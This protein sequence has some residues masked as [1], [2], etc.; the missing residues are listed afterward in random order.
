MKN[1]KP[2]LSVVIFLGM[3]F[4]GGIIALLLNSDF[5]NTMQEA[6]ETGNAP[7]QIQFTADEL[8]LTTTIT[9]IISILVITFALKTIRVKE[10]FTPSNIKHGKNFLYAL[11]AIMGAFTGIFC[12]DL[13]SEQMNLPNMMEEQ[14]I[15]MSKSPI[16]IISIGIAAPLVEE[17]VFRESIEGEML[18]GGISPL[19]AIGV[20]AL[21][22]G[23]IHINPV[24]VPFAFLIGIILGI[25]YWK[26]RNVLLCSIVHIANNTIAVIQMN[27]MG[28]ELK[29]L[30]YNNIFGGTGITWSIMAGTLLVSVTLLWIFCKKFVTIEKH[31][32]TL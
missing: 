24:Q 26:T 17:L 7:E 31:K 9:G 1:W 18:R 12:T 21:A 5:I 16:G 13:L 6:E 4:L 14:F 15:A 30:S 29:E 10:T 28:D 22:F 23:I 2:L 32:Y 8:A 19:T 3:Q 27:V 11:I 25:L 20:S